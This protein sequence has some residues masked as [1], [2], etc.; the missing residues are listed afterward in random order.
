V[1]NGTLHNHRTVAEVLNEFKGELKDFAATRGQMLRA[2]M[3]EKVGAWKAALPT[4]VIGAVLLLLALF[5]FTA[6]LVEVIALA[7][8]G[9]PWA[10][11]AACFI[12]FAL[13]GLAGAFLLMYGWRTAKEFGLAPERT[14]K[15]LKQD[16]IW[17]Q[18]EART[19]L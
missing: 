12:V 9:Q 10:M 5:V 11:A 18:S 14:L 15:V 7:F 3:T 17:L 19:E 4:M 1:T 13:Y 16:Q 6:G 2:E 8:G